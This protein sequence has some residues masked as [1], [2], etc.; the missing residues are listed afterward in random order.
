VLKRLLAAIHGPIYR[1]R[2]E[3]LSDLLVAQLKPGDQVLDIGCGNGLLGASLA[4]H[5]KCPA[6][7]TVRGL[8]KAKRG[9]EP[10][11]VIP[12]AQGPLPFAS[13]SIDVVILADV[14]HHEENEGELLAEAAR[15]CCRR[16]IIKDH[17]PEGPLAYSRICFLDW[18]ANNPHGVKCLYRY[19]RYN[20]WQ[21]LFAEQ[22][23]QP[24]SEATSIDLYPPL[25]NLVFGKRLQYLVALEKACPG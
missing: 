5:P 18:A 9:N 10:I 8:E 11:D 13:D 7:V 4:A 2:I 19:H 6:G 12:H 3:V 16:L 25:F 22:R 21:A 1:K 17:K 24:L 15:I 23:L 20:E 14:L